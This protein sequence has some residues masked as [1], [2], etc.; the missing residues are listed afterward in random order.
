[1]YEYNAKIL[2][3][4]DGDSLLVDVS[5]GFDINQKIKLRLARINTPEIHGV[6]KESEEYQKGIAS[7][8]FVEDFARMTNNNI[9]IITVKDKK[10][11]YGRYLAEV[12]AL[13]GAFKG[14]NLNDE[15]LTFGFA[16]EYNNK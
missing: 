4:I 6:L 5:L 16:T 9:R 7:M 2:K 10:E 12:Y 11:K 8:K 13:E 14:K 15:M 3:I 1:M